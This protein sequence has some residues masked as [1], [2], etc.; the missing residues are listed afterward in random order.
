MPRKPS[1]FPWTCR[2]PAGWLTDD[3]PLPTSSSLRFLHPGIY[4]VLQFLILLYSGSKICVMFG[5]QLWCLPF[6][7]APRLVPD[8]W[9]FHW[10]TGLAV[11]MTLW[12]SEGGPHWALHGG[13]AGTGWGW[14]YLPASRWV[15]WVGCTHVDWDLP[16]R[17]W[18][19][20]T[21]SRTIYKE[22][23]DSPKDIKVKD[24]ANPETTVVPL[25]CFQRALYSQVT[26]AG[27]SAPNE[28]SFKYSRCSISVLNC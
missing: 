25:S 22:N 21:A 6:P 18:V 5:G 4:W 16:L 14:V 3:R 13:L 8:S 24:S 17:D 10:P 20:K 1:T 26:R 15:G 2:R 19:W 28:A 9:D 27:A 23:L 12:G 11:L 7:T